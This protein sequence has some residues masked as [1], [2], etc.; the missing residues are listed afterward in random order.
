MNRIEEQL[1]FT[2]EESVPAESLFPIF[3]MR[4]HKKKALMLLLLDFMNSLYLW[5][6]VWVAVSNLKT[7]ALINMHKTDNYFVAPL[8]RS[9]FQARLWRFIRIYLLSCGVFSAV[10]RCFRC[11]VVFSWPS[12]A[13]HIHCGVSKHITV[14]IMYTISF[15]QCSAVFS[16]LSCGVL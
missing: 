2:E 1:D 14:H 7:A 15:F 8:W 6:L 4:S 5:P 9:N 12:C 13:V 3:T 16:W 11:P 10:L